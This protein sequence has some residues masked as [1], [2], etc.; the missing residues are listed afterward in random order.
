MKLQ[1][2]PNYFLLD[3]DGVLNTGQ[4][5]YNSKGKFGKIFGADDNDALKILSNYIKIEFITS[6]KK[7]LKITNT[8]LLS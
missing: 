6:D 4:F 5:I 8:S 2:K 1:K 7:G 3:V